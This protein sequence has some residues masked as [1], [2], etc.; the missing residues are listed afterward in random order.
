MQVITQ[1]YLMKAKPAEVFAALTDPLII[2]KWSGAP[3]QM[4]AQIGTKFALFG[5]Q[6][7][8][9]NL[10]SV[11]GK[12][13]VQA[14]TAGDWPKPST[15]TF[16]LVPTPE[17]TNVELQHAGVPDDSHGHISEGWNTNYLGKMQTMFA[18]RA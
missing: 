13:L 1:T 16:T 17:G 3:A 9:A 14:W 2:Q 4:D 5:G 8:G 7:H 10:E 12:K 18:G 6:I 15:V 11:P